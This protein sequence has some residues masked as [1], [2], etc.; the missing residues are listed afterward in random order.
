MTVATRSSRGS[1][2]TL[3]LLDLSD[4][5]LERIL[6][7]LPQDDV[8]FCVSLVC[9]RLHAVQRDSAALWASVELYL[10]KYSRKLSSHRMLHWFQQRPTLSALVVEVNRRECIPMVVA[11][12]N[13]V[14]PQL[15]RLQLCSSPMD[16][17]DSSEEESDGEGSGGAAADQ[18]AR[19]EVAQQRGQP[20]ADHGAPLEP[21]IPAQP[22]LA[23]LTALRQLHYHNSEEATP[24][25]GLV[26]LAG[27]TA[28]TLGGVTLP[29][30]VA[31][32][33]TL[34]QLR[35]LTLFDGQ[36]HWHG[37]TQAATAVEQQVM[38]VA[39]QQLTALSAMLESLELRC[40]N[41][42][43]VPACWSA[44]SRL[45]A[46]QLQQR[47]MHTD[48]VRHVS[49]LASLRTLTLNGIWLRGPRL[50][51]WLAALPCLTALRVAF[52]EMQ[53]EV[54]ELQALA[55]LPHLRRLAVSVWTRRGMPD[56]DWAR[57]QQACP[58]VTLEVV[59]CGME[60]SLFFLH[61]FREQIR[62]GPR[63]TAH[64]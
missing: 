28:L 20:C 50:T 44:L 35:R 22:C 36:K 9:K 59:D 32:T 38:E 15:T 34:R 40:M 19:Q 6:L 25:M 7:H 10:G 4:E 39:M 54:G 23:G 13:T 2:S 55:L 17:S 18:L 51:P 3:G 31:A 48:D 63:I 33:A 5:L 49:G 14:G 11:L 60:K 37:D 16:W 64:V 47:G 27:L 24:P 45:S 29:W 21:S 30:A 12:L 26:W 52:G 61:I 57:L 8:Q 43:K 62:H 56:G 58:R 53:L 42:W 1:G 46:L 41:V